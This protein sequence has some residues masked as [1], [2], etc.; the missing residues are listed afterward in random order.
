MSLCG[1]LP[2]SLSCHRLFPNSPSRSLLTSSSRANTPIPTHNANTTHP[3]IGNT[4]P[5][6]EH[7]SPTHRHRQQTSRYTSKVGHSHFGI[8]G[9]MMLHCLDLQRSDEALAPFTRHS[10]PVPL[11]SARHPSTCLHRSLGSPS[12]PH[13]SSPPH[14]SPPLPPPGQGKHSVWCCNSRDRWLGR[15]G[16]DSEAAEKRQKDCCSKH[17]TKSSCALN[18]TACGMYI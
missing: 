14:P 15:A 6:C 16:Q 3:H 17:G 5:Q 7:H 11:P 1:P 18:V 9:S 4:N 10:T 8:S 2:R 12:L 13:P